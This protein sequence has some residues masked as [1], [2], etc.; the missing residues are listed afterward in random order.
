MRCSATLW[1]RHTQRISYQDGF[2]TLYS[3]HHYHHQHRPLIPLS[4][5]DTTCFSLPFY[6]ITLHFHAHSFYSHGNLHI[7]HPFLLGRPLLGCPFIGCPFILITLFIMWLSFIRIT[8]PYKANLLLTAYT[9]I[10]TYKLIGS[11]RRHEEACLLPKFVRV[12]FILPTYRCLGRDWPACVKFHA[13][14]DTQFRV[15]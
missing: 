15:F 9:H 13:A 11:A 5:V 6:S 7:V 2:R 3:H 4:R 8:C 12:W 14:D 1:H 10:R